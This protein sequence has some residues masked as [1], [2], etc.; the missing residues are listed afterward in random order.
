MQLF[1]S[2]SGSLSQ[3]VAQVLRDWLPDV[4]QQLKPWMSTEDIGKGRPWNEVLSKTLD[5]T[6]EGVVCL[7]R[8]NSKSEWL[9]FEAGALAKRVANTGGQ[10]RPLLIDLPPADVVGP[11][12]SFQATDARNREDMRK[13][14]HSLNES[15]DVEF[16]LLKERVDRSFEMFWP[17]LEDQLNRLASN[18]GVK[19]GA[20][21]PKVER[22]QGDMIAELV[23]TVRRLERDAEEQKKIASRGVLQAPRLSFEPTY[24]YTT[25]A[26][27][28]VTAA[29]LA[30]SSYK[31]GD[32]TFTME[33]LRPSGSIIAGSS[34]L[35]SQGNVPATWL[36]TSIS[37]PRIVHG[38]P[39]PPNAGT[40]A[41]AKPET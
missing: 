25:D 4:I 34:P 1:I 7:T 38:Q 2:W 23:E 31:I 39:S 30:N 33:P 36:D 24:R 27:P 8:S 14:V 6:T 12:A 19:E 5:A 21:Q 10:V 35:T 17:R 29:G 3:A 13:L 15:Q 22:E 28:S 37:P 40:T 20:A 11:L 16:R 9:N 32:Q 26:P 41:D 18:E